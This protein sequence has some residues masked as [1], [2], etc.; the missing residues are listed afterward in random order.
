M[1]K[2][3]NLMAMAIMALG[4]T[5][6]TANEDNPT[7]KVDEILAFNPLLQ[8][9]CSITD[10]EQHMQKKEWWQDGND[11]L[12]Y[13]ADP[14]ES[15]HKWYYVDADN[16]I[17]EQYLFE[18]EN[19]QNLRYAIC[20]CWNESVPAEKFK[21]TLLRQGFH[22]TGVMV[23]FGGETLERY[24][25]ADGKTEA[26]YNTD[27]DGYSQAIYRPYTTYKYLH[28]AD[29]RDNMSAEEQAQYAAYS[30]RLER[31]DKAQ[32]PKNWRTCLG[33]FKESEES[34]LFPD[35][36]YTPSTQGLRELNISG[37]SDLSAKE[38]DWVKAEIQKLTD[39]PIYII[40]VRGESH[41]LI[42]GIH[43]SR[44]GANNWGN[45]GKTHAQIISD[46]A[47]AI[48]DCLGQTIDIYSLSKSNNYQPVE[49]DRTTVEVTSAQTEEEACTERGLGYARF[50]VPDRAFPGDS[51]LE[52]FVDFVQSLPA[53]AWLHFHCQAGAGRTTQYMIFYDMMRNP[54][55]SLKDIAYRQCLLGGNYLLYDGSAPGEDPV[56]AELCAEKAQM[57]PLFYDYIQQN[58]ATGYQTKWGQWKRQFDDK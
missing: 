15:W 50:T 2:I 58:H 16:V 36:D 54:G 29:A 51:E 12:E 45:V 55:L 52:A 56:K 46:E 31:K 10:V 47:K 30:W 3:F 11:K 17:T 33:E 44:Y 13:W 5:A 39:G 25:S 20:V 35:P 8:W 37:S 19:G 4:F 42:N 14:Y 1:R 43:V 18:T 24:L 27:E 53:N 32:E 40:D 21:N 34:A 48:H 22:P 38:M 6:C 7:P 23:E 57:I 41:G 9:G 28:Y 26:L 49:E